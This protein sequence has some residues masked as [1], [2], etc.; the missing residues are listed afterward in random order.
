MYLAYTSSKL[1]KFIQPGKRRLAFTNPGVQYIGER[2]QIF[3]YVYFVRTVVD[4]DVLYS[5]SASTPVLTLG[6]DA[7]VERTGVDLS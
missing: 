5:T 3:G 4:A 2:E 6:V 7:P 1:C